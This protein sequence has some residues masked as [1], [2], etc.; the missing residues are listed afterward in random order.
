M[1]LIIVEDNPAD[2]EAI[3]RAIRSV[4]I[5]DVQHTDNL[6]TLSEIYP[7]DESAIVLLDL[8]LPGSTV[9]ETIE[10]ATGKKYCCIIYTGQM[11][12]EVAFHLGARGLFY[13][14]KSDTAKL[15]AALH[16]ISGRRKRQQE[17]AQRVLN[18]ARTLEQC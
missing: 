9:D 2:V 15:A 18:M 11:N 6:E 16:W 17:I 3:R 13:V 4:R 7:D 5:C 14:E 10:W 1:K 8:N 12:D